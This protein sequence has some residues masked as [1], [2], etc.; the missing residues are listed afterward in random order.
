MAGL[1][2]I[3]LAVT[4]LAS[5][6]RRVVSINLC[7]DQLLLLLGDR[8]QIVSLSRLARNPNASTLAARARDFPSNDAS[9]ETLITLQP[10]LILGGAYNDAALSRALRALGQRLETLPLANNIQDIRANI[11]RV[12][13]WLGHRKRGEALIARMDE[14]LRR[15]AR[16]RFARHP[17][18]L[19][20][21]PNG[22]TAGADTLQDEALRRAGWR[23]LAADLGLRGYRPIDLEPL[24]LA[25]P[26]RLFTSPYA[27][28]SDSL[29]QRRLRHP[30][31]RAAT[32]GRPMIAL[33]YRYWLCGGPMIVDAIEALQ[34]AH[35]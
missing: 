3:L 28:G 27:P 22:Y 12:A 32:G 16:R 15:L 7:A 19:F 20:Y 6:P 21:Q 9:L 25:R 1:V 24:L 11:R 10:D 17:R 13:A 29:A 2:P 18:A 33:P 34:G 5:P 23:N 4:C 35:P 8:E 26:E 31:L 30:A 14:R